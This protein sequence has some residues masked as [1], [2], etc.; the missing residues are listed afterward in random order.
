[1]LLVQLRKSLLPLGCAPLCV[2]YLRAEV[3]DDRAVVVLLEFA[4]IV[5][6]GEEIHCVTGD[7]VTDVFWKMLEKKNHTDYIVEVNN[8]SCLQN[9]NNRAYTHVETKHIALW[10]EYTH[11]ASKKTITTTYRMLNR[12]GVT[13]PIAL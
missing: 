5:H 13:F 10:R 12:N 6:F 3:S 11:I 1:M 8:R 2:R 7:I 4:N 9:G